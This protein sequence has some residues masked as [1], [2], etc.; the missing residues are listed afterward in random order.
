LTGESS[1]IGGNRLGEGKPEE[2]Q[3]FCFKG[4]M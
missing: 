4:V 3:K 2:S 1:K